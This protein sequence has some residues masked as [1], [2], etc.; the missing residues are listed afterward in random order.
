MVASHMQSASDTGS[1]ASGAAPRLQVDETT[2]R[3]VVSIDHL[4]F[5]IGRRSVSDLVLHGGDVSRDHAEI[6]ADGSAFVLR[7]RGSRFGVFVNGQR[8]TEHRLIA[9]DRISFGRGGQT[10]LTFY[11]ADASAISAVTASGLG[12]DLRQIGVLLEA[13]RGMGSGRVLD[14]VLALVLDTAIDVTGAERGFI[15][16]A[17]DGDV[18]EMKLARARGQI[19]LPLTGFATSRQ[20]PEEVFT[21]GREK[22][23]QDMLDERNENQKHDRTIALGIRQVL[24]A[25]LR[26]VR[27]L[28]RAEAPSEPR[29]IG[30][31][32]LDSR[33]RGTLLSKAARDALETLAIEAASAIE[34]ARLYRETLEKA[35]LDQELRTAAQIQQA[36]LPPP[37]KHGSF[38][39]AM[40]TSVPCRAIGG[41][42]FEYFDP[43]GGGFAFALGDVAGKGPPAAL[44]AA[45]LQGILTGQAYSEA[46]PHTV[47]TRINNALL[48]RGV[49]SRFA[50]AFYGHLSPSGLLTY[51]NA[52]HNPPLV[53][54]DEGVRR[55]ETG[56][57]I[58]GLFPAAE[59]EQ[60]SVQLAAGD[61]VVVFSDGVSEAMSIDGEEFGEDR[62]RDVVDAVRSQSPEAIHRELFQRVREFTRG[63]VQSDDIT[64]V[65]IAFRQPPAA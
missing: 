19:T 12:G 6:V 3:R 10:E 15:M 48:S 9:H 39:D 8:I 18:L 45:V 21:T 27:I 24:C 11:P 23:V 26:L 28:E 65:I 1:M 50:T 16:L 55:L 22:I 20:I 4:P 13:L 35:R 61:V 64:A 32:Y 52:G 40:G 7:D 41:D 51:C 2:G 62:I 59:Y 29:N 58:V 53:I 63:A 30:V 56:G 43:P 17:S 33:E 31:L 44:L 36:L 46:D 25:P 57:M 42:F 60:G 5:L 47:M 38:F 34:N 37:R 14:E 49:E 54:G